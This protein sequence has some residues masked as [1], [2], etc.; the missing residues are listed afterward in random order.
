MRFTHTK[1][2]RNFLDGQSRK[3]NPEQYRQWRATVKWTDTQ[4][5]AALREYAEGLTHE[6]QKYLRDRVEY[7]ANR[8]E[9]T[10]RMSGIALTHALHVLIKFCDVDDCGKKALYRVGGEGRCSK[11][12]MVPEKFSAAKRK[13]IDENSKQIEETKNYYDTKESSHNHSK[14]AAKFKKGRVK[15]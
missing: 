14:M 3:F 10:G 7:E 11:H 4:I 13:R 6:Q 2:F 8:I 5:V 9:Q 12:R 1:A 15:K